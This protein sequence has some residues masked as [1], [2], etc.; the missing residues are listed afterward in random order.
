M[1]RPYLHK[2]HFLLDVI[3]TTDVCIRYIPHN[4]AYNTIVY[5]RAYTIGIIPDTTR[6]KNSSARIVYNKV[7]AFLPRS[8]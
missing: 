7:L 8:V 1:V 4:I 3:R 6:C 2:H 5:F